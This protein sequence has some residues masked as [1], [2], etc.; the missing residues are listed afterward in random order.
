M[1]RKI[2]IEQKGQIESKINNRFKLIISLITFTVNGL[3]VIQFPY[4]SSLSHNQAF[5]KMSLQMLFSTFN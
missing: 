4:F 5:Q 3:N 2:N 1:V